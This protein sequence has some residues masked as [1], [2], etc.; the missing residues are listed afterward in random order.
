MKRETPGGGCALGVLEA[1][2]L[3]VQQGVTEVVQA[4][5]RASLEALSR[6]MS[7]LS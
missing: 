7:A 2:A 5:V 1:L 4:A 6:Q 3:R